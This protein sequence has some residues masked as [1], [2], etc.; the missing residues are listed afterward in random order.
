M[1][2]IYD[3]LHKKHVCQWKMYLSKSKIKIKHPLRKNIL[4]LISYT[5]YTKHVR[6]YLHQCHCL[7]LHSQCVTF[8]TLTFN[9]PI[10]FT[11]IL[12]HVII[13]P[14][15][16]IACTTLLNFNSHFP[17]TTLGID[18]FSGTYFNTLL[19]LW[20]LVVEINWI[21]GVHLVWSFFP[22]KQKKRQLLKCHMY[23]K[24]RTMDKIPKKKTVLVWTSAVLCS[25][26]WISWSLKIG[27]TCCPEMLARKYKS[28][29]HNISQERRSHMMI[30]WHRPLCLTLHIQ[31]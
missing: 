20:C 4:L 10:L 12:Q 21:E 19:S 25:H 27:P 17:V 31:I 22:W 24:N 1:T 3:D 8:F 6:F 26:F 30:W 13:S 7:H 23:L 14:I 15:Y 28:A 16:C 11:A 29:M 5:S 18:L 2:L 9:M